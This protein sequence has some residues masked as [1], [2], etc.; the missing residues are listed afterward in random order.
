MEDAPPRKRASTASRME[1]DLAKDSAASR[2]RCRTVPSGRATATGPAPYMSIPEDIEDAGEE[3]EEGENK[4]D[5]A[6]EGQN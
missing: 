6:E 3:V 4:K 1:T 5:E 2:D